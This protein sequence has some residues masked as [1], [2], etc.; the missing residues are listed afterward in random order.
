MF[1]LNNTDVVI[2][3]FR[4]SVVST[5]GLMAVTKLTPAGEDSHIQELLSTFRAN[6]EGLQPLD[7]GAPANAPTAAPQT[8]HHLS[9]S[10]RDVVDL[11]AQ[12]AES[13]FTQFTQFTQASQAATP[14]V[15][16]PIAAAPQG[17]AAGTAAGAALPRQKVQEF[18][19]LSRKPSGAPATAP[20]GEAERAPP[21][22]GHGST[23]GPAAD[24]LL[25]VPSSGASSTQAKSGATQQA[26]SGQLLPALS[27]FEGDDD[28]NASLEH[29]SW[30]AKARV[31]SPTSLPS[32]RSSGE[33]AASSQARPAHASA[34]AKRTSQQPAARRGG[35][36]AAR[37]GGSAAARRGG[38]AAAAAAAPQ[39]WRASKATRGKRPR[40]PPFLKDVPP[41]KTAGRMAASAPLG[42]T[43]CSEA[44]RAQLQDLSDVDLEQQMASIA[45]VPFAEDA[46]RR[47]FR[48]AQLYTERF[49]SDAV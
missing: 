19:F 12:C 1:I 20:A 30:E 39:I 8:S 13:Q 43:L 7:P 4:F 10:D 31:L 27:Q 40:D 22:A 34:Q 15:S 11:L 35:S 18:P 29:G 14:A 26:W 25:L 38:S 47:L 24:D 23:Q 48:F 44:Q 9:Q 36:A 2:L 16:Q 42:L 37:R 45:A 41:S 32:Q 17:A 49:D 28:D 33:A 46:H 5:T 21:A 6:P 3:I